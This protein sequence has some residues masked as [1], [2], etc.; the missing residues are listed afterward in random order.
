MIILHFRVHD[1]NNIRTL[2][3]FYKISFRMGN[4]RLSKS[5]NYINIILLKSSIIQFSNTASS[6]TMCKK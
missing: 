4:I 5:N 1:D 3:S 2:V 6:V